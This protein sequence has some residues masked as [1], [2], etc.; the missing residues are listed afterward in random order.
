[1][2]SGITIAGRMNLRRSNR[3]ASPEVTQ[4]VLGQEHAHHLVA[5]LADDGVSGVAAL[6]DCPQGLLLGGIALQHHHLGAWHHDVA[7]LGLCHLEHALEH[8][9]FVRVKDRVPAA[10][11]QEIDDVLA[12]RRLAL[13][14]ATQAPVE[15]VRRRCNVLFFVVHLSWRTRAR[16]RPAIGVVDS[17]PRRILTS[18]VPFYG[19]GPVIMAQQVQR[20]MH[21]QVRQVIQGFP[22]PGLG[23]CGK[24]RRPSSVLRRGRRKTP[25]VEGRLAAETRIQAPASG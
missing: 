5:V 24:S 6:D 12:G 19:L 15:W 2:L 10:F 14:Q 16:L 17:Q 18:A 9:D 3:S 7:H 23:S 8:G 20:A 1:L 13:H 21:H 4:D 22:V 11:L 25:D